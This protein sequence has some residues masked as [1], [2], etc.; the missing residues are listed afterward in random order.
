MTSKQKQSGKKN[1]L[2][3]SQPRCE[4]GT[5]ISSR[6]VRNCGE[7]ALTI[8]LRQIIQNKCKIICFKAFFYCYTLVLSV[9]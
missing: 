3:Y 4:P 1:Q 5:P 7:K 6:C 8:M 9:Q 2:I